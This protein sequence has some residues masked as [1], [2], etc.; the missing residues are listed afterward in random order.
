MGL[1]PRRMVRALAVGAVSACAALAGAQAA[2]AASFCVKQ[3]TGTC[4]GGSTQVADPQDA[5]NDAAAT[6]G[7]ADTID[8]LPGDYTSADLT[9]FT[10]SAADPLTITGDPG[11]TLSANSTATGVLS[12]DGPATVA[13]LRLLIPGA[14]VAS[15]GL[16]LRHGADASAL[17]VDSDPSA[18][19]PTGA[20]LGDAS[21]LTGSGVRASLAVQVNGPGLAPALVSRSA[22]AGTR[23]FVV[24]QGSGRIED[25]LVSAFGG[26]ALESHGVADSTVLDAENVTAN[27]AGAF[28]GSIGADA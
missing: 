19:H 23:G 1:A 21:S 3:S 18:D 16:K 6:V 17:T 25:S 10:Y 20:D 13:N 4:P 24:S 12:L 26:P 8:V 22:L 28:G 14:S 11:A 5:L 27:N 7:Q 2:S 15:T 9:G